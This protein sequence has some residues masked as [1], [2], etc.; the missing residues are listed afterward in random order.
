MGRQLCIGDILFSSEH[1][2]QQCTTADEIDGVL[3]RLITQDICL[4]YTLYSLI[5]HSVVY[6]STCHNTSLLAF[7]VR[8]LLLAGASCSLV[9]YNLVVHM[10]LAPRELMRVAELG[11]PLHETSCSSGSTLGYACALKYICVWSD[12]AARGV[13]S[14]DPHRLN[15]YALSLRRCFRNIRMNELRLIGHTLIKRY[16]FEIVDAWALVVECVLDSE[17]LGVR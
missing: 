1:I 10:R 7:T 6:R 12:W 2:F 13:V 16:G 17:S 9:W 15:A 8:R 5:K 11:V 4:G 14:D 3:R